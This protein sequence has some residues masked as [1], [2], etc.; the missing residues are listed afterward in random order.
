VLAGRRRIILGALYVLLTLFVL[1]GALWLYHRRIKLYLDEELGMRLSAI[2]TT[3]SL[4]IDP[5]AVRAAVEGKASVDDLSALR[6]YLENVAGESRLAGLYVL[7]LQERDLLWTG[8]GVRPAVI[9][10]DPVAVATAEAG[11]VSFSETYNVD[12]LY[13]KSGYAPVF[14]RGGVIAIVAAE[15]DAGY[16]N[17]IRQARRSLLAVS[18]VG[19]AGAAVL[20]VLLVGLARSISRAEEAVGRAN[21]LA[22]LG[23]MAAAVAH[24]IRNPLGIIGGAAQRLESIRAG[25]QRAQLAAGRGPGAEAGDEPAGAGPAEGEGPRGSGGSEEAELLRFIKEEVDR[26]DTIVKGYLEMAGSS[27]KPS[28]CDVLPLIDR[29]VGMYRKEFSEAGI[30]VEVDAP[31]GRALSVSADAAQLQQAFLNILA[32]ARESMPSGGRV[33]VAV[34]RRARE[35]SIRFKDT[36]EGI[37]GRDLPHVREPFFTKKPS[38]SGLGLAIVEKVVRDGGGKLEIDSAIGAGT[39]VTIVLPLREE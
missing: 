4:S 8:E 5:D 28:R 26:L 15:A 10:L 2:A 6:S 21:V 36:G 34:R 16:F 30:E 22:T 24:D 12:D 37:P 27:G 33:S 32:N 38:G 19:L 39:T 11:L 25:R 29:T 1:D 20:G 9:N 23:R 17:I 14:S 35:V 3:V 18:L 31:G 13:F 7:D